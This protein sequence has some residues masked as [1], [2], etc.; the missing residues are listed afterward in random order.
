MSSI[1]RKPFPEKQKVANRS[2]TMPIAL[3]ITLANP[4][5][6]A[7]VICVV[8]ST[9]SLQDFCLS[10]LT[11]KVLSENEGRAAILA[12]GELATRISLFSVWKWTNTGSYSETC[13]ASLFRLEVV[14][15]SNARAVPAQQDTHL[16]CYFNY[17]LL[18]KLKLFMWSSSLLVAD[19]V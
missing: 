14:N 1:R 6:V 10:L 16:D 13:L 2:Q 5:I 8:S 15:W 7:V 11:E 19:T 4:C 17:S 18:L 3:A 12:P 9:G